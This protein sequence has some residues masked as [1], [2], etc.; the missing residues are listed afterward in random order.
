M[1]LLKI[2]G[3]E[4]G[5]TSFNTKLAHAIACLG[6][7]A[8]IVHGGG[9]AVDEVQRRFGLKP[10]K[11]EG[12]RITDSEALRVVIMVLCGLV[13]KQLVAALIVGGVDAVGLSGVDSGL[14]RVRKLNHP[15]VDLGFVG[16]IVSVR[17]EFVRALLREGTIPVISPISLG[18]DGE[19]YNVNADQ[20][21]SAIA[22]ALD[23]DTLD[24][25]SN[26]PGVLVDGKV[27]PYLQASEAGQMITS[28][29][30]HSGMVPKVHAALQALHKG[31]PKVRIVDLDGLNS[32]GG[33]TFTDDHANKIQVK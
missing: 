22:L 29:E 20:A 23:V 10:V 5:Q 21:A 2:G 9:K 15:E 26:V 33:T 30:I 31:V 4:L 14:L 16:E 17:A 19:I 28:G 3:N 7:P 25:V 8:V 27:L 6:E 13:S 18:L 32:T 12:M 11:V 24:F 1:R